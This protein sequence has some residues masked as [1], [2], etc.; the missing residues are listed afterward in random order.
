M[1]IRSLYT[2]AIYNFYSQPLVMKFHFDTYVL[3]EE[4]KHRLI[5]KHFGLSKGEAAESK[6][7]LIGG[8]NVDVCKLRRPSIIGSSGQFVDILRQRGVQCIYVDERLSSQICHWC[9]HRGLKLLC[10][11]VYE[12][13]SV[14]SS[15]IVTQNDNDHSITCSSSNSNKSSNPHEIKMKPTTPFAEITDVNKQLNRWIKVEKETIVNQKSKKKMK[16]NP[17]SNRRIPKNNKLQQQSSTKSSSSSSNNNSSNMYENLPSM[18]Q[19]KEDILMMEE[20]P[21]PPITSNKQGPSS[22]SFTT[23]VDTT[24]YQQKFQQA[25]AKKKQKNKERKQWKET[26]KIHPLPIP[27]STIESNTSNK[28]NITTT[29][30][31]GNLS[32][33]STLPLFHYNNNYYHHHQ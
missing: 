27:F 5:A 3:R 29:D 9:N 21:L 6:L 18:Q 32:S 25:K 26:R 12:L 14:S 2:N 16:L 7:V 28:T 17:I 20:H 23:T 30:N 19:E 22:S 10:H 11:N 4:T 33:S 1:K 15:T 13:V 24:S 8:G 31:I